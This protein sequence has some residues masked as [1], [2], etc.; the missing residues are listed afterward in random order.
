[1]AV[2]T[3]VNRFPRILYFIDGP[4]PTKEQADALAKMG[5]KA[6]F[7]NARMVSDLPLSSLE[8][9]DAVAGDVPKR[10]AETYPTVD[11]LTAGNVDR[12]SDY[13]LPHASMTGSYT[14]AGNEAARA[15]RPPAVGD[16]VTPTA[17]RVPGSMTFAEGGVL[18]PRP[19]GNTLAGFGAER[20]ENATKPGEAGLTPGVAADADGKGIDG[21]P[22]GTNVVAGFATPGDSAEGGKVK[23]EKATVKS[24]AAQK[25]SENPAQ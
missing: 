12:P 9:C 16:F 20:A 13:D 3:E 6:A 10:Y 24:T 1:M 7:R 23:P 19:A 22:A 21:N 11:A 15:A 4:V 25:A 14:D 2:N 8:D 5:P 18:I 17:P